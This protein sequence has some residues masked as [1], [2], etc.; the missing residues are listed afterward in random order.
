M[1][2]FKVMFFSKVSSRTACSFLLISRLSS[3]VM[4]E[5]VTLLLYRLAMMPVLALT[6]A[7]TFRCQTISDR[8]Q[9]GSPC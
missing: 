6:W 5:S 8:Q 7:W 3:S 2:S 4:A 1:F 9:T